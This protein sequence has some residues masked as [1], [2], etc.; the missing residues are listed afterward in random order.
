MNKSIAIVS[1]LA[2]VFVAGCSSLSADLT[3]IN[4]GLVLAGDACKVV[5]QVNKDPNWLKVACQVEGLAQPV[6]QTVS[7]DVWALAS[8][9]TSSSVNDAGTSQ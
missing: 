8:Q 2:L 3:A 1:T 9:K 4:N 7:A 5:G 6:V